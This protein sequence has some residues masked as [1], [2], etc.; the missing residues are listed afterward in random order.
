[1]NTH[2][3][4]MTKDIAAK[5]HSYRRSEVREPA[6]QFHSVEMKLASLPIYLFKLKDVSS[7]SACF[8]VKKGSAILKNLKVGQILIL[9]YHAADGMKRSEVFKSEIKHITKALENPY[10]GHYAVG[11]R[12]LEKQIQIDSQDDYE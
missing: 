1:M 4:N 8:M 2:G 7:N 6:N 9:R 10:K 12:L 11:I 3:G 5:Y